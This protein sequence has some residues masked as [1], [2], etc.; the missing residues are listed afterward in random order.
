MIQ[1]VWAHNEEIQGD[2]KY[3]ENFYNG[4]DKSMTTEWCPSDSE[5]QYLKNLKRTRSRN[6]LEKHGWIDKK[7]TYSF[8]S[9]GFR[10]EEFDFDENE[11]ILFFGCSY[12]VGIGLP[13]ENTWPYIVSKN[14]NLKCFN[15]GVGGSSLDAMYRLAK[16]WIPKFKS[17]LV[18]VLEPP[19]PRY[20]TFCDAFYNR[21][22]DTSDKYANERT[23]RLRY[24]IP[25]NQE[26][27]LDKT[28]S[29]IE[30]ICNKTN[31]KFIGLRTSIWVSSKDKARDLMH[32]GIGCHSK[33][34]E[35]ITHVVIN[36]LKD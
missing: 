33:T 6:D 23:G 12:T 36:T 24:V 9:H 29:A 19:G 25:Y 13:T 15:L 10:S 34:A 3:P 18:I 4:Y 11:S 8:N 16:Y 1:G 14:L 22:S 32:P 26:I 20:E 5:K 17:K 30:N 28:Y 35:K 21:S 2:Y 7:I 27:H 31:K